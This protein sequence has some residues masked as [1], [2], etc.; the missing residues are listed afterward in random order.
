MSERVLNVVRELRYKNGRMTQ[1]SLA[2]I[3]GVSRRSIISLESHRY[4]WP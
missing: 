4:S 2:E 3:T 1:Q